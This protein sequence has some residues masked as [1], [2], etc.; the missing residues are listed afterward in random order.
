MI[1]DVYNKSLITNFL[2][3]NTVLITSVPSC[4]PRANL[5]LLFSSVPYVIIFTW[6]AFNHTC[7]VTYHYWSL[8]FT[9]QYTIHTIESS[10]EIL[11]YLMLLII[12]L[13]KYIY[14]NV[15]VNTP[16]IRGMCSVTADKPIPQLI[17]KITN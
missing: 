1:L 2:N 12:Y 15:L 7:I 4:I 10:H 17:H 9:Y 16:N 11:I 13:D 14:D 8:F 5:G 6:A 3:S